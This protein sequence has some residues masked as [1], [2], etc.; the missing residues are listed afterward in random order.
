MA[1]SQNGQPSAERTDHG[2]RP[3]CLSKDAK[4]IRGEAGTV[5]RLRE[6]RRNQP[7]LGWE[8]ELGWYAFG[9]RRD[10]FDLD[11]AGIS[12]F[13]AAH[14]GLEEA[15]PLFLKTLEPL[16]T[17]ALQQQGF[18]DSDDLTVFTEFLGP[19]SFAGK[20]VASDDKPL[21]LLDV[22]TKDGF[23]SPAEFVDHFSNAS[24]ARVLYRGNFTG[25]FATEVREGRFDV[26]VSAICKGGTKGNVWMVKIKTNEYMTRL[27]KSF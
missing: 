1:S 13:A 12:E 7:A 16:L 4:C 17:E 22:L 10:R 2:S 5:H 21:V 26:S 3:T 15:A 18:Y 20:H 19:N 23:L 6:V 25:Q 14:P 8:P 27:K 9:T 11:D 24:P